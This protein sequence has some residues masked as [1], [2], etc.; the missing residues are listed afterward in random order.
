MIWR[1]L[2]TA[3][4][5][6]QTAHLL[7]DLPFG[8]AWFTLVVTGL[9]VG[10][11]VF[12]VMFAGVVVAALTLLAMRIVSAIERGRARVLLDV[13]V[14]DPFRPFRWEGTWKER[15]KAI[16]ADPTSWKAVAYSLLL[17]PVGILTFTVTVTAWSVALGM[18]T[19]PAY[20]WTSDTPDW[21]DRNLNTV[22]YV[23]ALVVIAIAGFLLLAAVPH[24]IGGLARLDATLVRSLLGPDDRRRLEQQVTQLEQSRAASVDVASG[25]RTRIE[26]DLHDGVQ[27]RLVATAMEIGLARERLA[28]GQPAEQVDELLARAQEESKAAMGELR[29]LVRGIHPAILVDRG[30]EPALSALIARLAIPVDLRVDLPVRPPS[31]VESTAYFVVAEALTNVAKHAQA[32]Q[33]QV[34]IRQLGDTVSVSVYDDGRGGASIGAAGGLAGLRDRVASVRGTLR[35]A[36]PPGGPTTLIAELPCA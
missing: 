27:P 15:A 25:E 30:L 23:G 8:I 34:T 13:D 10:A 4:P 14:P 18:A 12:V 3:K 22:E 5:W 21:L 2:F 28:A 17:L 31:A 7:L 36:S 16:F 35:V 29:N 19:F 6:K 9:S 26:R 20:A 11:G 32:R 33:A 24:I 1:A